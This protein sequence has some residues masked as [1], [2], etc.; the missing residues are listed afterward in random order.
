MELISIT[1][2]IVVF[3]VTTEIWA[4]LIP[5]Y[6]TLTM[7]PLNFM[8]VHVCLCIYGQTIF[9]EVS[10]K[11]IGKDLSHWHPFTSKEPQTPF[12]KDTVIP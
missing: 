1:L 6:L 2:N 8:W 12:L 9:F 7:P 4:H 10:L 3:I 11:Q 5:I